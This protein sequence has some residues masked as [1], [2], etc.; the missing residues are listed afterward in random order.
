LRTN[1]D[2]VANLGSLQRFLHDSLP[3][4]DPETKKPTR[5]AR[6]SFSQ[7]NYKLILFPIHL[8]REIILM[9]K[10]TGIMDWPIVQEIKNLMK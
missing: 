5:A 2:V 6:I 7:M 8:I 9:H 4:V 3:T 10:R 1:I